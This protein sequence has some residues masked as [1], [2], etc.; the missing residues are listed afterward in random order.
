LGGAINRNSDI[1]FKV[2]AKFKFIDVDSMSFSHGNYMHKKVEK[3]IAV[4][5]WRP[6]G[7]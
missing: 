4:T 3:A 2:L 6:I 1:R 7:L 5:P